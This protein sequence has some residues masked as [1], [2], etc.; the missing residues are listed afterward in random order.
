MCKSE[1]VCVCV[2]L[3]VRGG[4]VHKTH[5]SVRITVFGSRF[6]VLYGSCYFFF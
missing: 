2:C 6:S 3:S 1:C 4:T 5:S